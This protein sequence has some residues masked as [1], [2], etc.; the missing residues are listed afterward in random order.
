[1]FLKIIDFLRRDVLIHIIQMLTALLPNS[2]ITTRLRGMLI[3]PLLGR[4]GK[5]FRLA[6][7]VIINKPGKL[8]IEDNVY[9]AHNVWIN[10]VGG[11]RIG[12][13]SVIGPMS[14]LASSKHIYRDKKVT[15]EGAFVPI[16]I[17]K[18]VW[19]ASHVVVTDG[20]KIGD[21]V[22]VAAGSVVTHHINSYTMVGGVPAKFI[23]KLS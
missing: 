9:I 8:L 20:V 14:V 4:C 5:N 2:Y 23:R 12:D 7:G 15:N 3:G 11:I 10:A 17:G 19:L 16:T 18:G 21:G 6:S 13:N 22:L 1:M